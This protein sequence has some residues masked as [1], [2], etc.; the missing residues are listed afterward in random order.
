MALLQIRQV[1]DVRRLQLWPLLSGNGWAVL[2]FSDSVVGVGDSWPLSSASLTPF[3]FAAAEKSC[4]S[5]GLDMLVASSA[6]ASWK[7]DG[8][9]GNKKT[10][11]DSNF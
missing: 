4:V 6:N 8:N 11:Q 7:Y 1:V 5:I 9:K 3:D 2:Q 10:R